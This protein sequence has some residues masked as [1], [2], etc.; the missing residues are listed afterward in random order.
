MELKNTI[1]IIIKDL[2]EAREIIDDLKKYPG[3]PEL[4]VEL[5]KAKCKSAAEVIALF[6]SVPVARPEAGESMPVREEVSGKKEEREPVKP[7]REYQPPV[8]DQR[9]A[10]GTIN[11]EPEIVVPPSEPVVKSAPRQKKISETLIIA[12]QFSQPAS[13]NEELGSHKHEDDVHELIRTLP[14][15]SLS[16]AIGIN[17]K[18]LFVREIFNGNQDA[19][20]QAMQKLETAGSLSDARA[21]IAGYTGEDN[22]NEAVKQLMDLI[23]RKFPSHE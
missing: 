5:A 20:N 13:F 7:V 18:F 6:K 11:P 22:E 12:D 8:V 15:S 1:D 2:N 21:I 23:K 4:Q 9:A 14:L 16:D 3:V 10:R 17:D 19:Y